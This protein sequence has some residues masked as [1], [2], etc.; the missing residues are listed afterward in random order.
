MMQPALFLN[1]SNSPG[2]N[3]FWF[4]LQA[5]G[6]TIKQTVQPIL[7]QYAM[8]VI[9]KLELKKVQF[10][11]KAPQITGTCVCNLISC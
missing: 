4:V 6:D 9:Q 1:L 11:N 10:G 2:V 3:C 5:A 8:G 7:D